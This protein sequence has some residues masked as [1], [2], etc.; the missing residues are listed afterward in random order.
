MHVYAD[1]IFVKMAKVTVQHGNV[2][3]KDGTFCQRYM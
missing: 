3:V 2:P 1:T